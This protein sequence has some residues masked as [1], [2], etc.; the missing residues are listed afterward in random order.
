[1]LRLPPRSTLFPYTTLFRSHP[2]TYSIPCPVCARM[3]PLACRF[4]L[5]LRLSY[6]ERRHDFATRHRPPPDRP[7]RRRLQLL[8]PV[9]ELR[10][11][12]RQAPLLS[13]RAAPDGE[14]G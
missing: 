2:G 11:Q 8:Q 4:P 14:G 7:L 3:A 1:M 13:L 5:I 12:A 9:R 6:D 10:Y